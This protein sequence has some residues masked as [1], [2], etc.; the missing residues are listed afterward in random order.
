MR[1]FITLNLQLSAYTV[2]YWDNMIIGYVLCLIFKL[3]LTFSV[4]VFNYIYKMNDY[5]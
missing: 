5:G 2:F 1:Y 3:I 4:K